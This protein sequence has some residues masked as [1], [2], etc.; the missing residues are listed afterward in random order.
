LLAICIDIA[1]RIQDVDS[2]LWQRMHRLLN[3]VGVRAVVPDGEPFDEK[4]FDAVGRADTADETLQLTVQSTQFCG[5]L[6]GERVLRKPRV[7]VYRTEEVLR[8]A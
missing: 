3:E 7:I 2:A 5:Y 6:D 1:D 8:R 4:R